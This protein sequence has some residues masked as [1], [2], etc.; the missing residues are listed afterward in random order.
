MNQHVTLRDKV[1]ATWSDNDKPEF[2][3]SITM[4]GNSIVWR[5]KVEA[6]VAPSER[7]G[8]SV[9]RLL[10]DGTEV[11]RAMMTDPFE[12]K[13]VTHQFV[14]NAGVGGMLFYSKDL[15]FPG[16][17]AGEWDETANKILD[18]EL[19]SAIRSAIIEFNRS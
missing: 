14:S 18:P 17:D 16:I 10:N 8:R 2:Q 1:T 5:V 19:K 12:R 13:T 4:E 7:K 11:R 3:P 15:A 6:P 9:W